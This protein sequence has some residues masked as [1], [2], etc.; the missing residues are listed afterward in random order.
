MLKEAYSINEVCEIT[1]L[2]RV[3]IYKAIKNG[4][5]RNKKCFRRTLILRSDLQDFL[6]GLGP[7]DPV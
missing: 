6:D 1:S 7:N 5:L 4:E 3:T 2:S